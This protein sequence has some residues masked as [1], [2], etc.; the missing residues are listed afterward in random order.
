MEK[1]PV[2][3]KMKCNSTIKR[4][5]VLTNAQCGVPLKHDAKLKKSD[6]KDHRLCDS[7]CMKH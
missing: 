4:K 5:G 7:S 3:H 6:T 2:I 1:Q